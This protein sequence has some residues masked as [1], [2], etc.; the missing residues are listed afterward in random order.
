[1]RSSEQALT[2]LTSGITSL[3]I[4]HLL[5]RDAARLEHRSAGLRRWTAQ[6]HI[7][8]W[9]Q[10]CG[11]NDYE[12]QDLLDCVRTPS[13][14]INQLLDN[15]AATTPL[16]WLVA[17]TPD[18]PVNVARPKAGRPTIRVGCDR[19]RVATVPADRHLDVLA[20]LDRGLDLDH[21]LHNG[22]LVTTRRAR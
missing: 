22:E 2:V 18:G 5:G 20:M 19:R 12:V 15:L 1:M 8:G 11:A 14:P 4:A 10:H 13:D 3:R 21:R 16:T 6:H 9:T 17:G 7:D